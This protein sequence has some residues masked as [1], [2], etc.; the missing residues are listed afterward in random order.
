VGLWGA[1]AHRDDAVGPGGRFDGAEYLPRVVRVRA[2][3]YMD[4][5]TIR[6]VIGQQ[7]AGARTPSSRGNRSGQGLGAVVPDPRSRPRDP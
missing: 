6:I 3:R 1:V 7:P 4:R 5:V 2:G